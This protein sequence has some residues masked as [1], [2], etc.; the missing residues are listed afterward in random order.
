HE[1][2]PMLDLRYPALHVTG[3]FS[4]S[5]DVVA[6]ALDVTPV[7]NAQ[8]ARF[9]QESGY[10]PAQ[11][12]HF[13][14]HWRDGQI[15]PELDDHPVVYVDL[16]DARAYAQWA[17][18][19]LPTEAEWQHAAQGEDE[20]RYPWGDKFALHCCN[21][22]EHGGT[23]PVTAFPDGRSVYGCYDMCGN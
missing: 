2:L 7:T 5:V 13:L 12:D 1:N 10:H 19:R 6:F 3:T 18:K 22:G 21:D 8:Y 11:P 17:G 23:T 9:L 4:Q 16:A 20:R 15:P 14:K